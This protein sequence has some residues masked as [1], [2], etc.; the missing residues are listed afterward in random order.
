MLHQLNYLQNKI[1][2][3]RSSGFDTPII[4]LYGLQ[5]F[6]EMFKIHRKKGL[7]FLKL[8]I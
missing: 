7:E 3:T 5:F 6:V 1:G 8:R 2:E 4:Q